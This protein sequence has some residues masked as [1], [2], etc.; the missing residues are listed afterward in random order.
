MSDRRYSPGESEYA[1][2]DIGVIPPLEVNTAC[3]LNN[4]HPL[5]L[6]GLIG[7]VTGCHFFTQHYDDRLFAELGVS[8]PPSLNNALPVRR[9][10]Y[11]AGR[12]LAK[13]NLAQLHIFGHK[14]LPDMDGIP[15]WPAGISGSLSH[16][17]EIALCVTLPSQLASMVGIDI[18]T[19]MS[20][21]DAQLLWPHIISAQEYE[22]LQ[23]QPLDF[24]LMLTLAFSAK[25]SFYKL[26]FPKTRTEMIFHSVRFVDF[27]LKS[28]MFTLTIPEE[29]ITLFPSQLYARGTFLLMNDI[30]VTIMR[31]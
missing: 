30:V 3:F 7:G 5:P 24:H 16:N 22:F 15:Q 18:E 28:G 13:R 1:P 23:S 8:F 21:E 20:Q 27:D 2:G 4:C 10:E 29:L 11:L 25:E 14:L 31:A 17:R 9:A 12:A 6:P 19:L 26:V